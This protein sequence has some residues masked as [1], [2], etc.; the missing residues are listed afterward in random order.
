[1]STPFPPIEPAGGTALWARYLRA[2]LEAAETSARDIGDVVGIGGTLDPASLLTA[3]RLGVFPMGLGEGG[4]PPMGWWCPTWR[5]VLEPGGVHVSRS[6]R[7]SMRRFRVT[8]DEAF[9]EVVAA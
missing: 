1:M 9:P 5:G 7:R 6:L 2:G 8:V 3:Y 4:G